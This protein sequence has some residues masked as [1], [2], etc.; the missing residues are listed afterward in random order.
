MVY[1]YAIFALAIFIA[2]WVMVARWL[3]SGARRS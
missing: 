1:L 2:G 3:I